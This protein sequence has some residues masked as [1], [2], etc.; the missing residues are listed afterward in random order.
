MMQ[1]HRIHS[2]R[3][4]VALLTVNFPFIVHYALS[5]PLL[6]P[7]LLRLSGVAREPC[8]QFVRIPKYLHTL[9]LQILY[10]EV[11]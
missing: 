9:D 2:T 11:D 1:L 3:L 8:W 4:I 5:Y 10:C 7:E 6:R